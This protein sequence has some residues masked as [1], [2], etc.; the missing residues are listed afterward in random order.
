MFGFAWL[1]VQ[2]G[3]DS[4]TLKAEMDVYHGLTDSIADMITPDES[5]RAPLIRGL[6]DFLS[7]RALRLSAQLSA[8]RTAQE[9]ISTLKLLILHDTDRPASASQEDN[10]P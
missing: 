9:L 8:E 6:L 3:N 10:K 5:T 7:Y 1:I 2:Q 4:P